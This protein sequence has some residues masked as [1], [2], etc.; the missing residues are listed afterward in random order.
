[1]TE[2]LTILFLSPLWMKKGKAAVV[3]HGIWNGQ[4]AFP[5]RLNPE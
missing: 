5:N 4:L 2:K 3:A 1:L